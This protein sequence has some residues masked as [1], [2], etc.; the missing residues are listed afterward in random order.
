MIISID[1]PNGLPQSGPVKVSRKEISKVMAFLGSKT[2]KA[3]AE[4]VRKNGLKG[5]RPKKKSVA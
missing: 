4:A 5:G 3:K 2:S 1:K